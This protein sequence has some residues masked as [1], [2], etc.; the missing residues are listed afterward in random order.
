MRAPACPCAKAGKFLHGLLLDGASRGASGLAAGA[1]TKCQ[2]EALKSRAERGAAS[3][4]RYP[5]AYVLRMPGSFRRELGV[6]INKSF[7]TQ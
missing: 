1:G 7:E 5:E 3:W 6:V 2:L 4:H